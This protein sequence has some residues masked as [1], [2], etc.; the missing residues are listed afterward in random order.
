MSLRI[1]LR[2]FGVIGERAGRDR[3]LSWRACARNM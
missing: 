2:R 1:E 3:R